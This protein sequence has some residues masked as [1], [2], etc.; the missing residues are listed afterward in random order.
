[1]YLFDM[2]PFVR[3]YAKREGRSEEWLMDGWISGTKTHVLFM[4]TDQVGWLLLSLDARDGFF[5]DWF[6]D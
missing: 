2:Y 6:P 3:L 1:M 4:A 5:R